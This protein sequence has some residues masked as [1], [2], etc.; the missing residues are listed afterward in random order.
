MVISTVNHT[1]VFSLKQKNHR[2][3]KHKTYSKLRYQ[4]IKCSNIIFVDHS[5]LY[6]YMIVLLI[7]CYR[8]KKCFHGSDAKI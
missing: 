6:V 3:F 1:I 4:Q 7:S 2:S 5:D 8:R